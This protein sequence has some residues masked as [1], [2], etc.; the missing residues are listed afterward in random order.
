MTR[1]WLL[2]AATTAIST[3]LIVLGRHLTRGGT[4]VN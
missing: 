4:R 2:L 3:A 1:V